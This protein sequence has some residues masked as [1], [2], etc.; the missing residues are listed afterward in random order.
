MIHVICGAPCSGKTTYVAEHAS[1]GDI[2][3]DADTISEALGG[4]RWDIQHLD[5]VKAARRAAVDYALAHPEFESWIIDTR[6][7]WRALDA[8][9][10]AGADVVDLYASRDVCMERALAA[11]RPQATLDAIDWFFGGD[12]MKEAAMQHKSFDFDATYDEADGGEL[13]AYASTF[14]RVPDSY[15]DIVAP[16]AFSKSL[17]EWAESGNPIPLL[18][19]HRTD[20]PR[21]NIGAVLDAEEDEKGLRIR[22]KFDEESEIAQYTRKLV[23]EG[24]LSKLSF[25]Y[26]TLDS[27]P[28]VLEDGRKARELRELKLYEI[29]LVPIPANPL[30]SVISAKDAEDNRDEGA[31]LTNAEVREMRENPA[32]FYADEADDQKSEADAEEKAADDWTMEDVKAFY[33][34]MADWIGI[35]QKADGSGLADAITT[36][37][38][39]AERL[40]SIAEMID[41]MAKRIA[42]LSDVRSE[43]PPADDAAKADDDIEA[44]AHDA[45]DDEANDN[46]EDPDE[47]N[48]EVEAKKAAALERMARYIRIQD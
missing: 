46:E 16:G 28:V 7:S 42:A 24:R 39:L 22:A 17:S 11:D 29:S 32:A 9:N 20:D 41:D 4:S 6:P 2:I 31:D 40:D 37:Q 34:V 45:A 27:A 13:V 12:G 14:D 1:P 18:F 21:M 19:G 38:T 33:D 48:S 44:K 30:T 23:K 25:S 10:N 47:D 3:I 36:L 43:E 5:M 15:G 26:D 8:Y 35:G